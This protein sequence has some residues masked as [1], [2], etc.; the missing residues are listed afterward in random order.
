VHRDNRAR[1]S[2]WVEHHDVAPFLPIFDKPARFRA[3]MTLRAVSA[4]RWT[5]RGQGDGNLDGAVKGAGLFRYGL[6]VRGQAVD[7]D[8]D[9]LA[10]VRSASSRLSPWL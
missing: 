6:A 3:R 8:L 2:V 1:V 10:D 4:A 5:S 7:V 9:G